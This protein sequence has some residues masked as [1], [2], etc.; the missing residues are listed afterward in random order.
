MVAGF[1]LGLV[2][3]VTLPAIQERRLQAKLDAYKAVFTDATDFT[4][5]ESLNQLI[6]EAPE[7][8]F[9][10]KGLTNISV[11]EVRIATD[12]AGN[13]L[14]YVVMVTTGEGY[15]GAI[16]VLLGYTMDGTVNGI[17]ILTISETAG[18]GAKAAE[19][20]FK[21]QYAKKKVTEFVYTKTGVASDNEI[22][23]IS[24]ATITTSAVTGAV[25]AGIAFIT[26]LVE[27]TIGGGQNE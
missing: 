7:K 27:T 25:N 21:D 6:P 20:S 11:D 22:D 23:A 8:V 4:E 5:D 14:G 13:K 12:S 19:K 10:A 16:T 24:G 9:E 17:E 18:L 15:G 3:D 1:A 26:D 2:Y